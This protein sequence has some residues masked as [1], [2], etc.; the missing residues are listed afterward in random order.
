MYIYMY[1]GEREKTNSYVYVCTYTY[2]VTNG[3][4]TAFKQTINIAK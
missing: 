2:I 4:Y 3:M 1:V